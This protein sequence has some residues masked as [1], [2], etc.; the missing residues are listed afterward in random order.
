MQVQETDLLENMFPRDT[1]RGVKFWARHVR[2]LAVREGLNAV[3]PVARQ[4]KNS[5]FFLLF[6]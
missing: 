2:P 4:T 6:V 1:R 3:C 5:N